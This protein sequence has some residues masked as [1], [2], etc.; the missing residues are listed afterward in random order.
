MMNEPTQA[1][2]V[3]CAV[4]KDATRF[5]PLAGALGVMLEACC[6]A[7]SHLGHWLRKL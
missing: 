2:V 3:H 4:C 6:E 5:R 1:D 7:T